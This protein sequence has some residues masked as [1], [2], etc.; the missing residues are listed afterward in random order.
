MQNKIL[1]TC[2]T[3]G[4]TAYMYTRKRHIPEKDK[5]FECNKCVAERWKKEEKQPTK[6][7]VILF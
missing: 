7:Q 4:A 6:K 3:C 5:V 2:K 1:C